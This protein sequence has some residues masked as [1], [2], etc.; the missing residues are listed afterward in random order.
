MHWI[1]AV[2]TGMEGLAWVAIMDGWTTKGTY[3]TKPRNQ[4]AML[5]TKLIGKG[6]QMVVHVFERGYASGP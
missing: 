6:G 2:I 5:L 4:E 1:G 3:A